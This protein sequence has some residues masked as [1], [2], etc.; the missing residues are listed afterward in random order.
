[1][2]RETSKA[3][4][5]TLNPTISSALVRSAMFSFTWN[6]GGAGW[7]TSMGLTNVFKLTN[8]N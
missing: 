3:A 6:I 2:A 4:R 5:E 7:V 1:M 8:I